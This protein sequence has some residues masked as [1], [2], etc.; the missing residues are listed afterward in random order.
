LFT[1]NPVSD[2]LYLNLPI[3]NISKISIFDIKGSKIFDFPLNQNSLNLENIES[4]FYFVSVTF[5]DGNILKQKI[6]KN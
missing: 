1:P 4:G 2:K 3:E 5:F 6:I